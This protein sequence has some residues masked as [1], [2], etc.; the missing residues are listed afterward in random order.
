MRHDF[1]KFDANKTITEKKLRKAKVVFFMEIYYILRDRGLPVYLGRI[2]V[3]PKSFAEERYETFHT[4]RVE[5][6]ATGLL[7]YFIHFGTETI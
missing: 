3:H 4:W 7:F 1:E 6:S 2:V 5:L